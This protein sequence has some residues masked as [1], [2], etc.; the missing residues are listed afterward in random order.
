LLVYCKKSDKTKEKKG[1]GRG[2]YIYYVF[3]KILAWNGTKN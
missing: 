2:G 3:G 1:G